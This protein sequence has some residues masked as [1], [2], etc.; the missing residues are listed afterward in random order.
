MNG[1]ILK[2]MKKHGSLGEC[3]SM[4]I[5]LNTAEIVASLWSKTYPNETR[6]MLGTRVSN[7]LNTVSVYEPEFALFLEV[8]AHEYSH[9]KGCNEEQA[10]EFQKQFDAFLTRAYQR[11][12][13]GARKK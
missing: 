13:E 11:D 5:N 1:R 8:A 7:W 3:Q 10:T 9:F 4:I 6:E 12:F 2:R